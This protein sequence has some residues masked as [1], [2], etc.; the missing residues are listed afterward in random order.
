M[1]YIVSLFLLI[2]VMVYNVIFEEISNNCFVKD[3]I[4]SEKN[5]LEV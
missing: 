3:V 2:L 4:V 5:E 1:E